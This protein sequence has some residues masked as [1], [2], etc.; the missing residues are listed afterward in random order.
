M[1][2]GSL[3]GQY[4]R[5]LRGQKS[6][7]HCARRLGMD[8]STIYKWESGLSKPNWD[9][10]FSFFNIEKI[11]VESLLLIKWSGEDVSKSQNILQFFL[12]DCS[13]NQISE[14]GGVSSKSIHSILKGH[15]PARVETIF[16]IWHHFYPSSFL[17]FLEQTVGLY[18]LDETKQF[19]QIWKLERELSYQYPFF[20][21]VI[22]Y[23]KRGLEVSRAVEKLEEKLGVDPSEI[24]N[25]LNRLTESRLIFVDEDKYILS[26]QHV[27]DSRIDFSMNK[28]LHKYWIKNALRN[29]EGKKN[30]T[31]QSFFNYLVT[32]ISKEAFDELQTEYR[33]FIKKVK[34]ICENDQGPANSTHAIT[35]QLVDLDENC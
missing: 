17:A 15:V 27:F 18:H 28:F 19:G 9:H 23:I 35:L 34:F 12:R 16:K 7:E 2:Y 31:E 30:F 14:I 8:K 3:V 4:F 11:E 13:I 26:H 24:E 22:A 25:L 32:S 33:Q 1:E 29:L 20:A 21:G 6:R 5:T 10:L